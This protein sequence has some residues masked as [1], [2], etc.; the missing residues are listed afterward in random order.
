MPL[1]KGAAAARGSSS[2]VVQVMPAEP[3]AR[4]EEHTENCTKAAGSQLRSIHASG[5]RVAQRPCCQNASHQRITSGAVVRAVVRQ[6][7]LWIPATDTDIISAQHFWTGGLETAGPG[8]YECGRDRSGGGFPNA[9]YE[10]HP[11]RGDCP[12]TARSRPKRAAKISRKIVAGQHRHPQ[13]ANQ[14]FVPGSPVAYG[15]RQWRTITCSIG[16]I[17]ER[18]RQGYPVG[19]PP[20]IPLASSSAAYL[21]SVTGSIRCS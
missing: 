1:F 9:G 20:A 17:G 2:V 18:P 15:G 7:F 14:T 3:D 19:P 4:A 5:L 21:P 13:A 16:P 10:P 12:L 8:C 6:R 11:S